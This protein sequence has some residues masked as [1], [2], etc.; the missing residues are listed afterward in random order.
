MYEDYVSL[1]KYNVPYHQ[2]PVCIERN[3]RETNAYP[4]KERKVLICILS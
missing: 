2:L 1:A 4:E 3:E